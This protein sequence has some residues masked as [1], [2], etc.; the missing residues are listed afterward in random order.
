MTIT[1]RLIVYSFW[2]QYIYGE[3]TIN[4]KGSLTQQH[5]CK[6]TTTTRA[7]KYATA[8][9]VETIITISIVCVYVASL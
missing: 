9:V 5:A 4:K 3:C 7:V 1:V 6:Q 2:V 8:A